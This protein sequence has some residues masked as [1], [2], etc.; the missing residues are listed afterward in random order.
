MLKQSLIESEFPQDENLVYLNHAAVSPW[1]RRTSE[2]IIKFATENSVTGAENYKKW[3][4]TEVRLRAQLQTLINAPSPDDIA[5]LKNTSE[6]ISVVASGIDWN[7]GDNVV[8]T[9]EEFPSNRFPWEAQREHGV[10]LLQIPVQG[11]N[12]EDALINACNKRTRVMSISSVQYGSGLRLDLEK[13]GRYCKENNILYCVDA[14][15]SIGSH[16]FDVQKM[17][18]DF[19]M[20]DAHKWMLGPEGI[21]L[22][23]CSSQVR[24]Q[25]KL[26]QYGWHMVQDAGNY[27]R[28]DWRAA[29]G[30]KRFECGS[31][32]MLGTFA[33]SASLSLIAEIGMEDIESEII[34]KTGYLIQ[35]LE[36]INGLEFL[37]NTDKSKLAGIVTFKL[38]GIDHKELRAKLIRNRVICAHRFGG[39]RFSPH[40]YTPQFKLDKAVD[41]LTTNI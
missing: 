19:A 22:F 6:A 23:Y 20:A 13:L 37:T 1:P 39:I 16:Q 31:P 26:H 24:E 30:A 38:K 29:D 35:K 25:I 15:Q 10:S 17:H 33:L 14:I 9:N 5:L 7:R 12:P 34:K 27:D 41:I 28:E 4:A 36:H 40:F 11:V 21:A 8:S 3:S 18:A 32:N 2:A